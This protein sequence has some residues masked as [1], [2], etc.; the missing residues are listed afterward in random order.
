MKIRAI[1]VQ[2][3]HR[4]VVDVGFGQFVAALDVGF[5]K[6]T[7]SQVADLQASERRT[8][9]WIVVLKIHDNIGLVVE[10]DL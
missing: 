7:G 4:A 1:A 6:S 10:L 2:K 5:Q 9:S 3:L 8:L